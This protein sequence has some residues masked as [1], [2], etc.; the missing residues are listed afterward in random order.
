MVKL[1]GALVEIRFIE[2]ATTCPRPIKGRSDT[3]LKSCS[4]LNK[5][6][7]ESGP[8]SQCIIDAH[9]GAFDVCQ[10]QF[11]WSWLT[12]GQ[13]TAVV[14]AA[15]YNLNHFGFDFQKVEDHHKHFHR[16]PP[17]HYQGIVEQSTISCEQT[18]FKVLHLAK[19]L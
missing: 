18:S 4:I 2:C 13:L 19:I 14:P 8:I 6:F 1:P 10:P 16:D 7:P 17:D 15:H 3:T 5:G 12:V 9:A 11:P